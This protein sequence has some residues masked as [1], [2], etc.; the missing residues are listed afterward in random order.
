VSPAAPKRN[1]PTSPTS[2]ARSRGRELALKYLYQAD[3]RGADL[4]AF[5]AFAEHQ[6]EGGGGAAFAKTLAA[7]VLDRKAEIDRLISGFAKNWSVKRMAII[8]RNI[9]RIGA[10]ELLSDDPPPRSVV[11]NEAIELA[12]R[13]STADS[14]KF[15]NGIL[16]RVGR[17]P[18]SDPSPAP[19]DA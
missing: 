4:E 7:G 13:F 15:I 19:G 12:K 5:D 6:D 14:G 3:V 1:P 17:D 16:D 18:A 2:R 10:F 11:I 8:D 9:L